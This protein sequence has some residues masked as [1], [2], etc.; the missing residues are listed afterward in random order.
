MCGLSQGSELGVNLT[1]QQQFNTRSTALKQ[2]APVNGFYFKTVHNFKR[3][4][5]DKVTKG[6]PAKKRV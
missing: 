5:V 2:L 3:R 6:E 4:L 1:I